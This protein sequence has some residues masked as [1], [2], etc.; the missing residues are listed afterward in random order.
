MYIHSKG[1]L[2]A[3]LRLDQWLLDD[4]MQPRL[5]DFNGSGFDSQPVLGLEFTKATSI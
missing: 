3:D 1:V 5:A 4:D 2:H